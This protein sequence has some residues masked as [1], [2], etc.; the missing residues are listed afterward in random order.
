MTKIFLFLL[1][2]LNYV[3]STS[4]NGTTTAITPTAIINSDPNI[5]IIQQH[6]EIKND[7]V[8]ILNS[9]KY[10]NCEIF[11]DFFPFAISY[12]LFVTTIL[13]SLITS[14]FVDTSY[15][16]HYINISNKFQ[17]TVGSII[18]CIMYFA[19]WSS[20]FIYSF[21]SDNKSEVLFRLG[22]WISLNMATVLLPITRN[23][24]WIILFK[25]SYDRIIHI[26]KFI[27]VLCI[28]SIIIKLIVILIDFNFVFL[29]I[30]YNADTGGSPLAGTLSSLSMILTGVLAI[31]YIRK[32]LFELFYFSHKFLCFFALATGVWHYLLTL[33]YILPTFVLY[34]IDIFL[35]FLNT[36]KA[37]YSH[38][39]I[40]GESDNKTACILMSI[41]LLKPIKTPPGSYFFICF[42]EISSIEWH[43]LSLITQNHN[44]LTFCVKD[45]G[46]GSWTNKIRVLDE[47]KSLKN[48]LK[49]CP[50]LLQG[51]YGHINIDYTN[52][53]YK[54]L[55]LIAGGIGITPILSILYDIHHNY[56]KYKHIKHV[57]LIWIVP[58]SSMVEGLI[59][60]L[61]YLD[62]K[63]FTINIY[64]TCNKIEDGFTNDYFEIQN[65]KPKISNIINYLYDDD[66]MISSELGVSCCGPY[67]LS[68]DVII[69]CSKLNIDI[70][71]ENF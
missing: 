1:L 59:F 36:K 29:F 10:I 11:H 31:P 18:F 69:T 24:I 9:Q 64:S 42:K 58:H 19:W 71:N 68:T 66:K 5:V 55:I 61:V 62:K 45:M 52:K 51:P 13:S 35:R 27:A 67:S 14:K 53:K 34:L 48:K 57:Y 30:P 49:D 6:E 33:Y 21:L 7:C 41:S 17:I 39:K 47:N 25:I 70:C 2:G 65:R 15:F 3:F 12:S 50:V 4:N 60:L 56:T 40:I 37:L 16:N 44:T 26:H 32:N 63:I 28:I 38:L 23:S 22:I 8:A 20:M 54:Y 43:P 46:K